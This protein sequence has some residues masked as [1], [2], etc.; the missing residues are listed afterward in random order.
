MVFDCFSMQKRTFYM[1]GSATYLY[2]YLIWTIIFI[3]LLHKNKNWNTFLIALPVCLHLKAAENDP[4]TLV[5]THLGGWDDDLPSKQINYNIR[6]QTKGFQNQQWLRIPLHTRREK[7]E[8]HC[9][10]IKALWSM[11]SRVCRSRFADYFILYEKQ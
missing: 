1:G 11:F 5:K 2:L 9:I 3:H 8:L 6:H 4:V 10:L 7:Q